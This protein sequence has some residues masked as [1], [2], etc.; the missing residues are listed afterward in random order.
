MGET[1]QARMGER[2]G[3]RKLFHAVTG[4]DGGEDGGEDAREDVGEDGG[5]KQAWPLPIFLPIFLPVFLLIFLPSPEKN[6][7]RGRGRLNSFAELGMS[8]PEKT[9]ILISGYCFVRIFRLAFH[10]TFRAIFG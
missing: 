7:L 3:E 1:M 8:P 5:E 2:M 6:D 10:L 9:I 4:E